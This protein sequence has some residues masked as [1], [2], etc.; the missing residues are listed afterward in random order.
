[1][2]LEGTAMKFTK[3]AR[4]EIGRT[5]D[6]SSPEIDTAHSEA[7]NHADDFRDQELEEK[8]SEGDPHLIR[9]H[10]LTFDPKAKELLT[11]WHSGAKRVLAINPFPN[12]ITLS[13]HNL[14]EATGEL[15]DES[16]GVAQDSQE[17]AEG[18]RKR[19]DSRQFHLRLKETRDYLV[20][21]GRYFLFREGY[22]DALEKKLARLQ[23]EGLLDD[24][25][26][27]LG[28]TADPFLAFHKRFDVTMKCL[29]L[30]EKFQPARLIIQTRSPMVISALP[31]LRTFGSRAAVA[32][33][34]ETHLEQPIVRYTPGQ[35]AIRD[36]WLAADGLRSQGVTVNVQVSPILPYGEFYRD[37]WQFAE[38]LNQH[39][40]FVTFGCLATGAH[41]DELALKGLPIAQ[42]L[43]ADRNF[44]WLRPHAYRYL[45]YS[46]QS[47]APEKLLLPV[48][49]EPKS[50]QL[51][52]FAA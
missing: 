16:K 29:E 18:V 49:L 9:L 21:S 5:G 25:V 3:V 31:I 45:Y 34:V 14:S 13:I 1:M 42:K 28:V 30:L 38:Q 44:R 19:I 35:P 12:G 50:S 51:S 32:L 8:E 10:Q 6:K 41:Q 27:Y 36:R 43:A 24:C 23:R 40:D 37:A 52:L 33:V 15:S 26:C 11:A 7:R 22:G 39:A 4:V 46:M 47:I 48:R 2:F 17:V 20:P